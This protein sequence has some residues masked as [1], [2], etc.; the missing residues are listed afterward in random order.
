VGGRV[1]L[2]KVDVERANLFSVFRTDGQGVER[3]AVD[4]LPVVRR[5][6]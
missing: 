5:E 2:A 6:G 4:A 1:G 3:I